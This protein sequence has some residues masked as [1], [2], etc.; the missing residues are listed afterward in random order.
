LNPF[1]AFLTLEIREEGEA[2]EDIGG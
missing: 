2:V 1:L